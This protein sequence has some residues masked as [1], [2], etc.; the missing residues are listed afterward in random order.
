MNKLFIFSIIS[1]LVLGVAGGT[2]IYNIKY[3][4]LP[5]FD[6]DNIADI[7][8]PDDDNDGWSDVQELA[9][10]TNPKDAWSFPEDSNKNGLSDAYEI[11][12]VARFGNGSIQISD[13]TTITTINSSQQN[14]LP[15]FQNTSITPNDDYDNDGL[16][17]QEEQFYGTDPFNP[18]TDGDKLSDG[19]EVH[20][21]G[22]DP[23]NQDTDG[24]SMPDNVDPIPNSKTQK[25]KEKFILS[26][27]NP[28]NASQ[29]MGTDCL[30]LANDAQKDSCWMTV[31]KQIDNDRYCNNIIDDVL[32]QSCFAYFS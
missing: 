4:P 21:Y 1:V 8:D 12:L 10:G 26:D 15:N 3:K 31:A 22:T 30:N 27:V 17:N 16:D 2:F 20:K 29:T 25:P 19:D 32:R 9:E 6:G 14:E 11:K 7:N 28:E 13:K 18:D 5:D 23:T 24:D